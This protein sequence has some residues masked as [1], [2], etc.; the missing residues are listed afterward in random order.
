MRIVV[1]NSD[2]EALRRIIN[3][4]VRGIGATTVQKLS[5]AAAAAGACMY[6][7]LSQENIDKLP[8]NKGTRDKLGVF[9]AMIDAF[10]EA[11]ESSD[12]YEIGKMIIEQSG[13]L[14][15][16]LTDGSI[17]GLA[18]KENLD[19][20]LVALKSFTDSKREEDDAHYR[21]ED[22]LQEVSLMSDLDATDGSSEGISLMTMHAAKGLEFR[23]V[24]IAG[25][26]ENIF[27][28]P[29]S[30]VSAR[31]VEEERRLFYVAITRAKERCY[32]TCAQNRFRYG[33]SEYSVPSRFIRDIAPEYLDVS[34]GTPFARDRYTEKPLLPNFD[35]E[36]PALKL[37]PIVSSTMK[38]ISPTSLSQQPQLATSSAKF[39]VKIGDTIKHERFGEGV[40]RSIEGSGE[41]TKAT[42]D[43][44]N[45][46][47][48]QLLLKFARFTVVTG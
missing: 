42:V 16:I 23:V 20:L 6:T 15:D 19:E 29:R 7:M 12:A 11:N 47:T 32:L 37:Q 17:E 48:K 38:R 4:P 9:R 3:Y 25:L 26:E 13:I 41:N 35:R 28:S 40:I 21:L 24:F 14:T 45:V 8:L 36:I 46:G 39:G 1:N 30:L 33:K 2:D 27:P 44:R 5:A 22:F 34:K 31:A 10:V 43:F 18:K